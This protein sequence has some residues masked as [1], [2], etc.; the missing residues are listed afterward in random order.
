LELFG[1]AKV[2]KKLENN[3]NNNKKTASVAATSNA[4]FS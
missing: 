3:D 4:N 1:N 2:T